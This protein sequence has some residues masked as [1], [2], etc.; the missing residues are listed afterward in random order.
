MQGCSR[1]T[2]LNRSLPRAEALGE[3]FPDVTFDIR[4]MS[5]LMP[6]LEASDVIFA[7]SGS[8]EVLVHK[9][10]V[11]KF[12]PASQAVGGQRRLI[13]ISVPRNIAHDINEVE[14]A[15]VYNV[16]GE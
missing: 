8:E 2:L 7:A 13:D 14:G 12:G 6:C 16:D 9:E 3:E 11:E 15:I 1:V 4:L 10:D 5:D